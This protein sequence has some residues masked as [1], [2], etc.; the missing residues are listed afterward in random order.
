MLHLQH[1]HYRP[2]M[3]VRTSV[4]EPFDIR[5]VSP[6]LNARRTI[7]PFIY[8]IRPPGPQTS[9]S[10]PTP[11]QVMQ[12]AQQVAQQFAQGRSATIT[13]GKTTQTVAPFSPPLPGYVGQVVQIAQQMAAQPPAPSTVPTSSGS[14]TATISPSAT[15]PQQGGMAPANV[16]RPPSVTGSGNTQANV[17]P[18][19]SATMATVTRRPG[20]GRHPAQRVISGWGLGDVNA[21]TVTTPSP[22]VPAPPAVNPG[23]QGPF[24]PAFQRAMDARGQGMSASWWD[25]GRRAMWSQGSSIFQPNGIVPIQNASQWAQRNAGLGALNR[26]LSLWQ[27]GQSR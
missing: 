10:A 16:V 1:G 18:S 21:T 12:A 19:P 7:N 6:V 9:N 25:A 4:I 8:G 14:A 17:T 22:A 26:L 13:A 27:I 23:S 3:V 24:A 5:R 11:A 20:Q 2:D 15:K